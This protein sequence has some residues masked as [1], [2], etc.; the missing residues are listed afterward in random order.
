MELI[1]NT[2]INT[3]R[4]SFASLLLVSL[5]ACGGN[6]PSE[7]QAK[8]AIQDRLGDCKYFAIEHFTKVNGIPIDDNDY[9]VEVKY[10]VSLTPDDTL[11]SSLRDFTKMYQ[12]LLVVRTS[13]N[14]RLA[15]VQKDPD[16]DGTQDPQ[17]LSIKAQADQLAHQLN[18]NGGNRA[19][20]KAI[21]Q[22]CPNLRVNGLFLATY[23]NPN[24]SLDQLA[25]GTSAEFTE[26]ISMMKTDNGWQELR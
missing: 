14:A 17:L 24:V 20:I 6:G 19:F 22:E 5:A 13:Y 8:A 2:F 23:F 10:T 21:R 16:K 12:Q 3:L 11:K 1:M 18:S 25:D 15:E 26:T 9:Q 4:I 7:S